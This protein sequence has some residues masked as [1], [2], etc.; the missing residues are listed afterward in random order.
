MNTKM[1]IIDD[2]AIIRESLRRFIDWDSIGVE[3]CDAAS[4]GMT[5]MASILNL[6]PDIILTDI[7][8]PGLDGLELIR[9]LKEQNLRSEVIFI[10]AYSNF[11]YA[12]QAISLGA[13]DYITKPIDEEELLNTVKRCKD[14]I[15][16]ARQTQTIISSYKEDQSQKQQLILSRLLSSRSCLTRQEKELLKDEPWLNGE[17]TY[18]M[19]IGLWYPDQNTAP[20]PEELLRELFSSGRSC[21]F[22]LLTPFP[23]AQFIFLF[24]GQK[25]P[26]SMYHYACTCVKKDFFKRDGLLVT[27]SAP[28]Q[29]SSNFS[30]AYTDCALVYSIRWP[31]SKAGIFTF[32]DSFSDEIPVSGPEEYIERYFSQ[33]LEPNMLLPMLKDFLVYFIADGSVYDL[34]FMKLQFIRLVDRWVERMR[35]FHLHEYLDRDVLSA[36]KSIASQTYFHHV[37]E[38]AYHLFQNITLSVEQLSQNASKQL[39]RNSVAYIHEHFGENLTLGDLAAHLYVSPTYLSK[40]FSAEMGQPFSKYLQEYRISKAIEYMHNPQYKLYNIASICGFSDVAYFSKI[41]KSVT[42]MSP[43]QYRNKKL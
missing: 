6:E 9:L 36:E 25:T 8:M 3:I 34:E 28:H 1:I 19:A 41:F 30:E 7:R 18:M 22:V 37:Y 17:I 40:L 33:S 20:I 38:T 32:K 12:R 21:P 15:N 5:A 23:E 31:R 42:G 39:V 29:W 4:N 24:T 2:E 35:S 13:F 10:S 26:A 27:I 11:E 43:N 16:S 14:K